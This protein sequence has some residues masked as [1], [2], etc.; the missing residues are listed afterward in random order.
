MPN[1]P[2]YQIERVEGDESL[3]RLQ[4]SVQRALTEVSADRDDNASAASTA[5]TAT[6]TSYTP[7]VAADWATSGA[8]TTIQEALDRIAAALGPI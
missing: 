3:S 7:G 2:R 4:E 5:A 6:G 1:D 8:P